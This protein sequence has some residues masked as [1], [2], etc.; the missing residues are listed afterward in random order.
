VQQRR[1]AWS[2]AV[3]EARRAEYD[4]LVKRQTEAMLA[5]VEASAAV[6]RFR[7]EIE[8]TGADCTLRPMTLR[9][10][11][12]LDDHQSMARI[13]LRELVEHSFPVP[14]PANYGLKRW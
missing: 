9:H 13:H 1:Q 2:R 5:L 3:S 11:G 7:V 4:K 6:D 10:F 8:Q 14:D 12:R